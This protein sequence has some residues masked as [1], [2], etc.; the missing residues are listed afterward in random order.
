MTIGKRNNNNESEKFSYKQN[1][2]R[3]EFI[4]PEYRNEGL[5]QYSYKLEN[6]DANWSDFSNDN[7]KEYT[8]LRK[9]KYVFKVRAR[10]VLEAQEA[11]YSYEFT[12]LPAWY[13]TDIAF[14]IYFVLFIVSLVFLIRW[15]NLQSKKG[16]LDMEKRKEIEMNEQKKIFEAET[17][18]KKREI[19]ELKNQ[20]L[21][22]ELR[23]KSQELASSTMNIIRKNEMLYE[24]MDNI[25]KVTEEIR[26]NPQSNNIL[27]R[28]S[29]MEKTI[30]QNIESD[31]NWKKFEENFDLV[32]ENY[33]KRLG[34]MYPEL[35]TSDKRLCAYLK[36]DLSSKDI[37]PLLNMSIRSVEMSRYRLR[38]KMGLDREVNLSEFLQRL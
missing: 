37:A 13:E 30:K 14:F 22:Y 12:I 23:H 34:E 29:K 19:K 2:L 38:K 17:I 26:N 25:S 32:Y 31:D 6:Y 33:L 4:A 9:G 5:V 28:L 21:Q 36:M 35:S 27:M 15:I 7:I 3:L 18:E 11:T 8:Q 16:A 10:D 24:M 20:Q 1:S